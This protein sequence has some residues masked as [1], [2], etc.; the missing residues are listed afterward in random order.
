M[1]LF[2][3]SHSHGQG[4]ETTFA[5]V[6]ADRL[7]ISLSKIEVVHG[8]SDQIP[9]GTGTYGSRSMALGGSSA[10]LAVEKVVEKGKKIAAHILEASDVDIEFKKW[11]LCSRGHRQVDELWGG[12]RRS[13]SGAQLSAPGTS[14]PAWTRPRSTI[15][16]T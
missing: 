1:T 8:D 3:G 16:R 11:C 4:H 6:V 14:S 15:R 5:Q 7:G 12:R 10:F 13:V 9:F 2:T